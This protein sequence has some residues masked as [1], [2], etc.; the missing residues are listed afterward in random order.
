MRQRL[1]QTVQ[2]KIAAA[3]EEMP[4]FLRVVWR[5]SDICSIFVPLS[6]GNA[7]ICKEA[8]HSSNG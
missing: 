1:V 6:G 2:K 5:F 3:R 8:L 7:G 4:I